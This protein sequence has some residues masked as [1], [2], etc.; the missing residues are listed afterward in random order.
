MNDRESA[1]DKVPG[2]LPPAATEGEPTAVSGPNLASSDVDFTEPEL[3]SAEISADVA[4]RVDLAEVVAE[5]ARVEAEA[6]RSAQDAE[7]RAIPE[8]TV[9]DAE[10][11][12]PEPPATGAPAAPYSGRGI[13]DGSG[14]HRPET[15][16]QPRA[17]AWQS[18]GQVA[19][20]E[21]DAAAALV[22]A[23]GETSATD[24]APSDSVPAASEAPP[25]ETIPEAAAPV[26]LATG[27]LPFTVSGQAADVAAGQIPYGTPT[28]PRETVSS[29]PA[30][31]SD[32]KNK[33]FIVLGIVV[34]GVGLLVLFIWLIAS[35]VSGSSAKSDLS[36]ASTTTPSG[37]QTVDPAVLFPQVSP[38]KWVA[39]D[40]L[41]GFTTVTTP[42]DVVLCNSPHSA[43]LVA[44]FNYAK[45]ATFPGADALR[46][47]GTE[48]CKGVT[49]TAAAKA[50]AGLKQV[51]A[52]PSEATWK[53]QDD[54]R[55]DCFIQDPSGDN[56]KESLIK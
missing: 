40:C 3:K 24:N 43:Q 51:P 33:L 35:L 42:A 16:W 4:D 53:N 39:G 8:F 17:N 6:E 1:E 18:P 12:A 34:V 2:A 10:L 56:L 29:S 22:A 41:R 14:W 7:P 20:G 28:G 30:S 48:V 19:K 21:E 50:Y 11:P 26:E 37:P 49:L 44:T 52:Y 38:L 31:G 46:A 25:A 36:A 13:D 15:Q 5:A 9:P 54:R 23:G 45:D 32:S 55:V 27:Q 47:K